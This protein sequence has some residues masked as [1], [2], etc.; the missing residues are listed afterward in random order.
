MERNQDTRERNQDTRNY[1]DQAL[2]P[3]TDEEIELLEI[4]SVT[5]AA[6]KAVAKETRRARAK[7]IGVG[8]DA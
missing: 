1:N 6:Q 8:V 7:A 5:D 4:F 3:V 2:E